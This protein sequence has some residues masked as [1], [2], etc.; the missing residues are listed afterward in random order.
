MSS[1]GTRI[2]L[3]TGSSGEIGAHLAGHMAGAGW[4]V[5]GLDSRPCR[6]DLPYGLIFRQCNLADGAQA[7]TVLDELLGAQGGCDVLINCAGLIANAPLLSR[8]ATGWTTH[9]FS[10]WRDVIDAGLTTAFHTTALAAKHMVSARKRGVVI[11]IS[12]VCAKGNPGQSAYSATKAG[13]EGLTRALAKEL[14]PLGIRVVALAPG[15]FETRST[16]DNVT[17]ARL[18][19]VV[20]AV[21]LKRL[22]APD[23][24]ASA[25]DFIIEN[26]YVNGTIIELDGGLVL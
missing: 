16:R 8:R 20:A 26:D 23:E 7:T 15:Y 3:I 11:N 1:G 14:G 24:I 21:P 22:G 5:L 18:A 13:L 12:S 4:T 2:A 19:K 25:V 9:D 6:A 17:E 10:L